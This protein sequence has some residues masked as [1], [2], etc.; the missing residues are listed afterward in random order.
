MEGMYTEAPIPYPK[1]GYEC[2]QALYMA[3]AEESLEPQKENCE[4]KG[5]FT[6]FLKG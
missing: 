4:G 2:I 6:L 3:H 5:P 1:A